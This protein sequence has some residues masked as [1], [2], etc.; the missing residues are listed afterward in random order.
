VKRWFFSAVVLLLPTVVQA[1]ITYDRLAQFLLK[2]EVLEGS[3]SQEKYL[4]ALDA[5]L[6]STGVFTYYRGKSIRWEILKP[7]QSEL[8]ITPAAVSSKQGNQELIHL[9]VNNNP[10]A[11][12][13]GE[14]FFAVLTVD[15]TKLAPYFELSGTIEGQQWHAI[16]LPLDQTV[17]QIFSRI[18]LKGLELLEEIVLHEKSGD[19]TT[20]RL[21]NQR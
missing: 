17:A 11:R 18:E 14:I 12:V 16:L 20:I 8:M 2:P 21:V 7:I 15:W 5:T 10:V 4:G 6:I 1:E 9:D 19:R 13:I 3:F